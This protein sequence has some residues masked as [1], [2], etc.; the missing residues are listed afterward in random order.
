MKIE[1]ADSTE[2]SGGKPSALLTPAM[3]RAVEVAR[4]TLK[5]Q[6]LSEFEIEAELLKIKRSDLAI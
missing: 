6:G 1:M 4:A 3:I 2:P 5:E